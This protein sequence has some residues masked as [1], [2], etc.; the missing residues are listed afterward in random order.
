M[1][2]ISRVYATVDDDNNTHNMH[3]DVSTCVIVYVHIR[4]YSFVWI[5]SCDDVYKGVS[6]W[7]AVETFFLG[8]RVVG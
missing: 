6:P 1:R 2:I 3:D 8:R 7:T 4:G 5:K